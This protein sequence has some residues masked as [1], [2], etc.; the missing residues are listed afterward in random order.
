MY[1]KPRQFLC[2]F[3][4]FWT[5]EYVYFHIIIHYLVYISWYTQVQCNLLLFRSCLNI[6][7]F[8][9]QI[10]KN[11]SLVS[12][13]YFIYLFIYIRYVQIHIFIDTDPIIIRIETFKIRVKR[14][15]LSQCQNKIAQSFTGQLCTVIHS[16]SW[17]V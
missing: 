6:I 3:K 2:N 4:A 11:H 13:W 17:L 15:K 5:H 7:M 14:Y 10:L 12:A 9:L 16:I 8:Q 1:W